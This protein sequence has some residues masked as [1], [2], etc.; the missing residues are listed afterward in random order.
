MS[1]LN[2]KLAEKA[3]AMRCMSYTSRIKAELLTQTLYVMKG[4]KKALAQEMEERLMAQI[5]LEWERNFISVALDASGAFIV[6]LDG[7]GG[8]VRFNRAC[9]LSTGNAFQSV[10]GLTLAQ[11]ALPEGDVPLFDTLVAQARTTGKPAEGE[12]RWISLADGVRTIQWTVA[13]LPGR[14]GLG[15]GSIATGIDVT[16]ERRIRERLNLSQTVFDNAIEGIMITDVDGIIQS[17]NPA[18]TRMT[19]WEADEVVGRSPKVLRSGRHDERFYEVLWRSLLEEGSWK[20]EIWNKRKDGEVFV[21]W[22]SLT[23][24]RNEKGEA[25]HF[26]GVF[27]DISERKAKEELIHKLAYHDPL[28]G[29]PNRQLFNERISLEMAHARR[30]RKEV[31]L[32]YIDLDRFKQINDTLGHDVGDGVLC[33]VA[34]RLD[35]TLRESDTVARLGGD[36]FVIIAP[37]LGAEGAPTLAT[38]I[39]GELDRPVMVGEHRLPV[40]PSIGVAL[41][42]LHG[43]DRESLM[44]HADMAMY[45]AKSAGRNVFRIYEA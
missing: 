12:T 21:E 42:P 38:K 30:D 44:R 28:T 36:E 39:L 31:A 25:T 27:D 13:A 2:R 5:E 11:L 22:L 43:D 17:V 15:G 18:F 19:G 7:K 24:V 3:L 35:A 41:F 26:V 32:L 10:R 1:S 14:G 29:L 40:T 23:A 16:E 37:G 9:Q 6:V 8:V 4:S 20:G 34:R 45:D 33:E